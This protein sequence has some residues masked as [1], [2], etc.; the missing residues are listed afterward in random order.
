MHYDI[1]HK[2]RRDRAAPKQLDA[3]R[4]GKVPEVLRWL[5]D[6]LPVASQNTEG[7]PDLPGGISPS[8]G[9]Y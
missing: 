1:Q 6:G 2:A 3:V 4:Q 7:A 8:V 5:E 9:R